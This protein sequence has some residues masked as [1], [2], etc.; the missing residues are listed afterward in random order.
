MGS[1]L[2]NKGR[3]ADRESES[4]QDLTSLDVAEITERFDLIGQAKQMAQLGLPAFHSKALCQVELGVVRYIEHAREQIQ[5]LP[6]CHVQAAN[7]AAPRRRQRPLDADQV[8]AEGVERLVRQPE[9]DVHVRAALRSGMPRVKSSGSVEH[10]VEHLRLG[11]VVPLHLLPDGERGL[12]A[13]RDLDHLRGACCHHG[14]AREVLGV[15][16]FGHRQGVD[17]VAPP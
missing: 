7:P 15:R 13:A 16:G 12:L 5:P 8:G 10:V 3:S 14:D 4:N 2:K 11:D 1:W 6:H 17:V 9:R